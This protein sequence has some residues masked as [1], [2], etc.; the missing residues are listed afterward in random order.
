V[1]RDT[2]PHR[3]A[4]RLRD[5]TTLVVTDHYSTGA[6]IIARL[7]ALVPAPPLRAPYA[8]RQEHRR[9]L[10]RASLRLLAPIVDHRLA[11]AGG[12]PIGLLAELYPEQ[13]RF[14]LPF[15]QVQELRGAWNRYRE[16]VHL[17]VLGHRVHPYFGTYVP[18]RVE[19]LEL[20]AT[21]LSQYQGARAQGVDVGTGCGVLA[22]MLCRAG[23][24]R[25]LATD[26]SPNA[27]ESVARE[28]QRLPPGVPLD[29]HQGDLLAQVSVQADLIVFNPP[30]VQGE[31][32]GLL[33]QALVFDDDLLPR[34]FD[35]ASQR[36]A[37]DGRV[38][39]L[40]SNLIQLV[41]PHLAHP[42]LQELEQDRFELV[43]KLQRRVKPGVDARGRKRKTREKVEVWE[44]RMSG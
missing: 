37:P 33:D 24:A 6:E 30:W 13:S 21:W 40:F 25:V 1:D 28:L 2:P 20:F 27:V 38:V 34:F 19:H 8:Q 41:Q 9:G 23:F 4:Q 14:W 15:V 32:E 17:A 11:L 10:R 16:G 44:L 3:A 39:V 22:L 43:Q 31:R 12:A 29:L 42:I 18:T 35:Q 36:L 5:G 7:Q 26:Q